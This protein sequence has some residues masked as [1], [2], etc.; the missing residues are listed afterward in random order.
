MSFMDSYA[1]A[2]AT[3]RNLKSTVKR[4]VIL[5]S[6]VFP[7]T[8][9]LAGDALVTQKYDGSRDSFVQALGNAARN[10]ELRALVTHT[11][12]TEILE[13]MADPYLFTDM[14]LDVVDTLIIQRV[15]QYIVRINRQ[16]TKSGW[17]AFLELNDIRQRAADVARIGSEHVVNTGIAILVAAVTVAAAVIVSRS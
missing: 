3:L 10:L 15:G 8:S 1:G 16:G 5:A 9:S 13:L 17:S 14:N 7:K 6:A 11:L 12:I 4:Q 2:A